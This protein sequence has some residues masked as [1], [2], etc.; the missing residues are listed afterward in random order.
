MDRP[1]YQVIRQCNTLKRSIVLCI[2]DEVRPLGKFESCHFA[3]IVH[4]LLR[5]IAR[6]LVE[7]RIR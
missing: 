7:S 6:E 2:H 5:N 3:R 1:D 4:F